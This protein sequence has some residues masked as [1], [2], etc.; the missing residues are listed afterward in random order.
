[1]SALTLFLRPRMRFHFSQFIS[2]GDLVFDIGA[3]VGDLTQLF[4]SLG[5]RVVCVDPQPYCL[6]VLRKR[7]ASTPNVT[8]VGKGLSNKEGMLPFYVSSRSHS[9]CT[10]SKKMQV[11]GRY[12]HRAWDRVID[13]PV[14][15]LDALLETFGT[16]A[17]CKIDVE[18]FELN[19]IQGLNSRIPALSFEFT[20]EFLDDAEKCAQHLDSLGRAKFNYSLYFNYSLQGEQWLNRDQLF[21]ELKHHHSRHLCGDIYVRF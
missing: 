1:M 21:L 4:S 14:T 17:F 15:T 9:T 7:F 19:V 12:A 20:R 16:P 3:N 18:G 11:K 6:E 5:A 10:F 8:I 2:P 13:V